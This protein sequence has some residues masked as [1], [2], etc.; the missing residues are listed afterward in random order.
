[1]NTKCG[2]TYVRLW[3]TRH[4]KRVF[5]FFKIVLCID[6]IIARLFNSSELYR[7]RDKAVNKC[8]LNN[9][10]LPIF[11]LI[12]FSSFKMIKF[13]YGGVVVISGFYIFMLAVGTTWSV[14]AFYS[15]FRE[16]FNE[17][18]GKAQWISSAMFASQALCSK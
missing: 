8:K 11:T 12:R 17:C 4:I 13:T 7:Y 15:M 10:N 9:W 1:M 2:I 5:T 6:S 3:L 18:S 14:G 16:A